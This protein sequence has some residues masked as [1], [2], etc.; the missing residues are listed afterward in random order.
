MTAFEKG[1]KA[2]ME[3]KDKDDNPFDKE[4]C[5]YSHKEWLRGLVKSRKEHAK[6]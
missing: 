3:G 2:L 5:P 4:S 1:Y 6:R